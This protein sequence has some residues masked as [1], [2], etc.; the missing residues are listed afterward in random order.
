MRNISRV[1]KNLLL[2]ILEMIFSKQLFFGS[3]KKNV[4]IEAKKMT[5]NERF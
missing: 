3:Y 4:A 5:D 2:D 1:A